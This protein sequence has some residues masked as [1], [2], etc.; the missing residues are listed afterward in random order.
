MKRI[1]AISALSASL[2]GSAA[3]TEHY[4]NASGVESITGEAS[5]EEIKAC[6]AA[7]ADSEVPKET[8][9]LINETFCKLSIMIGDLALEL[10][11]DTENSSPK[12]PKFS[13]N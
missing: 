8:S 9:L 7:I 10:R 12:A 6:A 1:F 2:L 11:G 3:T 13:P 5:S 4:N